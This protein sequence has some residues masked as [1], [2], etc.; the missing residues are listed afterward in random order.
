MKLLK[1]IVLPALLLSSLVV[2]NSCESDAEMDRTTDFEK[3][4]IVMSPAQEPQGLAVPSTGIGKMDVFYTKD[5]RT[6]TYKV[7]WSGLTDSIV[8]MHIHGLAPVGYNAAIVQHIISGV[9]ASS[10][11]NSGQYSA[12]FTA[13]GP[14]RF[15]KSGSIS[16]TMPV[17]EV[18]IKEQDLLN[19][20]YYLN[21]HTK[22][23]PGG[24]IRGQI[25]F[26]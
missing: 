23:N 11:T 10:G 19:G 4:D 17:D 6:L 15:S 1:L 7:T 9:G 16:G 14:Y 22:A 3:K 25:V 13:T 8:G 5:T 18:V 20:M 12:Q 21:I 24:E 26:Q 2:L